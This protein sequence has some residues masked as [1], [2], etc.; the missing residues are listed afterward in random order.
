MNHAEIEAL[1]TGRVREAI[2]TAA[3]SVI[4]ELRQRGLPLSLVGAAPM[5]WRNEATGEEVYMLCP[6]AVGV[7]PAES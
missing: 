2:E 3:A 7:F 1:L 5:Q 4:E 6:V